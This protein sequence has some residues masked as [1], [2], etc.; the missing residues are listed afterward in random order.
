MRSVCKR[1]NIYLFKIKLC[2]VYILFLSLSV[3]LAQKNLNRFT[4]GAKAIGIGQSGVVGIYNASS[5]Y[6]NPAALGVIKSPQGTFAVHEPFLLNYLGYSHFFPGYG[7]LALGFS[8]TD[9]NKDAV[10]F[11]SIGWGMPLLHGFY[12]GF[13]FSGVQQN[14]DEWGTIGLGFML[15]PHYSLL[16]KVRANDILNSPWIAERLTLGICFQNVPLAGQG[17]DHQIRLGGSY[18]FTPYGP[19]LIA[20]HHFLSDKD[21]QHIGFL[22][23][24]FPSLDIFTGLK[25]YNPECFAFGTG[26]NWENININLTYNAESKRLTFSAS[27]RVGPHPNNLADQ[28]YSLAKRALQVK[29]KRAA[30]VHSNYAL[31]YNDNHKNAFDLKNMLEPLIKSENQKIDSLLLSAEIFKNRELYISAAA[32]YLKVLKINPKNKPAQE[33]I[34]MIRP[35]VNIHTEKW[36]LQGVNY[37]NQGEMQKAKEIFESIVLVRPDHI[38]SN[39]YLKKIN[40]YFYNQAE[41]HFYTGLGYYSQ[42]KLK[43]AESEF[44][45]ALEI[46]P[47]YQDASD[48]IERIA[49]EKTENNLQIINLLRDAQQ[50][51]NRGAWKT[52]KEKY[53]QILEVQPNHPQA[54]RKII[55]LSQKIQAYINRNYNRGVQAYQDGDYAKA[56]NFFRTVLTM[57]P[58]HTGAQNYLQRITESTDDR[59]HSYYETAQNYIEQGHLD[60]AISLIDSLLL[61]NP[62]YSEAAALREKATNLLEAE[63]LLGSAKT[64][65]DRR[66]YLQAME[67]FNQVIEKDPN[68]LEALE[69]RENCQL[70]LNERVDE[71]FNR[72][73]QLYTEEK[74]E[75]AIQIWD[76]VL[77]INPYHRGAIEYKERAQERLRA[78]ETL[79]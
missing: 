12:G 66:N 11:G 47:H 56:K 76:I 4:P 2:I 22:F 59:T 1:G 79:E 38:G 6:W 69:L 41:Q 60:R 45:K 53:Q 8:S 16:H 7:S 26:I 13:S 40:D 67:L 30:L 23:S 34:A 37:F 62:D 55:E 29:D 65:Y 14:K 77:R 21:T 15:K 78:L 43:L 3:V 35:K 10:N 32:Q 28:H 72:G 61:I 49:R 54:R 36:Y 70:R 71:Y 39:D 31:A 58:S 50:V 46:V 17:H 51:E 68:N 33:A 63:Q 75:E 9:K 48:Y 5:L 25:D 52:A 19:T 73:I 57:D 20:A 42:R 44:R 27:L 74:Y 64:E 24:P 18:K